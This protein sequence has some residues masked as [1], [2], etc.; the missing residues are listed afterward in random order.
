MSE[1]V[2]TSAS[3]C[4]SLAHLVALGEPGLTVALSLDGNRFVASLALDQ[5]E[6]CRRQA[7][8]NGP[9]S[10]T[11]LLHALW[12]LPAGFAIAW[13]TLPDRVVERLRQSGSGWIDDTGSSVTRL[14]E[15]AGH[16]Q[17]VGVGD[18][19]LSRA[20]ERAARLPPVYTRVAIWDRPPRSYKRS[21][22]HLAAAEALGIGVVAS[23][24]EMTVLLQPGLPQRGVPSVYRW[25]LAELAYRNWLMHREPTAQAGA[26]AW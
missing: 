12:E 3:S 9:V 14:Y 15:P 21:A 2:T 16:L 19:R 26:L 24:D 23:G 1:I 11:S 18:I 25:W 13:D 22:H 17:L 7:A 8:G 10:S 20:I 6:H 5:R 4:T